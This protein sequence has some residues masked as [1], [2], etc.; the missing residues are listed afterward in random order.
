MSLATKS[1]S[2]LKRDAFLYGMKMVT[3]III[4]RKLGPE[5][6]GVYV[7]LSWI[8]TYADSFGRLKFD[9]AA[10]YFLG[11]NKYRI[12]EVART[13]NMFALATSGLIV[14]FILWRF[15]WIYGILFSKTEYDATVL[16]YFVL[17]QI[18]VHFF[19]MNYSY[20]ILHTG[21]IVAYNRM[22]IISALVS[23]AASII[24]LIL[25]GLGLWAVIVSTLLGTFLSLIYGIAALGTIESTRNLFN[26]SLIRDL[27]QY[28]FKIYVAGLVGHF[29]NYI[30]N[31]LTALYLIPTQVSFF[32]IARNFG[33]MIDRVPVALNT[34]LLPQLA[35]TV[36]LKESAIMASRAFRLLLVLL[37]VFAVVASAIVKP[38]VYVMYGSEFLPLVVPFLILIPG[39]T[40]SGATTPLMQYFMSINRPDL[41]ATLPILPLLIQIVLAMLI[42]PMWGIVGAALAFTTGLI[43]L[44]LI[45]L[46]VFIKLS[47]CGL[48][49]HLMVRQED[50]RYLWSLIKA[51]AGRILKSMKLK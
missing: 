23:S 44:S 12:G 15:D 50:L 1:T 14:S 26:K 28:G 35:K 42:I 11:K 13:L 38:V 31:L 49:D 5:I 24:L 29:Q 7:I 48:Q 6:F 8:P 34:V 9:V 45:S 25:F 4:A 19:W 3:S 41:C 33:Q 46:W 30:T 36:D 32:S 2:I 51:E 27:F 43:A 21:N 39:I 16:A 37:I 47:G 40:M 17:L 22:V 10:V 20:L 18:P